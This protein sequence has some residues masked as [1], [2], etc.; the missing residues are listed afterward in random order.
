MNIINQAALFISNFEKKDL[1]KYFSIYIMSAILT[2]C[3]II[4]L[5]YENSN[6]WHKKMHDLIILKNESKELIEQY[7]D[8]EKEKH[9]VNEILVQNSGFKIKE[10]Y[11]QL[12][13]EM[14]LERFKSKD[15]SEPVTEQLEG[16]AKERT[17]TAYFTNLTME[18]VVNILAKIEENPLV[19]T[20]KINI[21][22]IT[23]E[24]PKLN[25]TIEISTIELSS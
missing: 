3:L 11:D 23:K 18:Q 19:Y 14:S 24:M 5:S 21:E 22:K 1:I 7:N 15:P 2:T 4:Y 10:Y 16:G 8:V 13:S 6:K 20:K 25:V 12:I 9:L 17:L